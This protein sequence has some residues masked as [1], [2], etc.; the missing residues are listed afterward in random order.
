L[1]VLVALGR[2][3]FAVRRR[4]V[5]RF[6]SQTF[7]PEAIPIIQR[8]RALVKTLVM[9]AITSTFDSSLRELPPTTRMRLSVTAA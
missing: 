5:V 7:G 6:F 2:K 9:F 4:N 3:Q 8:Q 1:A